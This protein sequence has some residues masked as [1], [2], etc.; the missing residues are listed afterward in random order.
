MTALRPGDLVELRLTSGRGYLLVTH[1]HP[2]Y[3]EV[4]YIFRGLYPEGCDPRALNRDGGY[5]L[6]PLGA[7]LGSELTGK[8]VERGYG[9]DL[10]KDFPSFRID[11]TDRND[12]HLY[13]WIWDGEAVRPSSKDEAAPLPERRMTAIGELS[14]LFSRS[15]P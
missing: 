13:S 7:K 15:N 2:V 9:F 5:R 1:V 12:A 8:I 3:S 4:V 14:A 11:V 6:F 10:Q